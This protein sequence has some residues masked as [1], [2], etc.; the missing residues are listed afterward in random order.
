MTTTVFNG[1]KADQA[2]LA[3]LD[4]IRYCLLEEPTTLTPMNGSLIKELASGCPV[5]AARG[6]Y[7]KETTVD[8]RT[9]FHMLCNT[10]PTI[11][12]I[13]DAIKTRLRI[14]IL[15]RDL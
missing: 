11:E 5:I 12:P 4:G 14:L 10:I 6:L 2:T 8:M 1:I 13:D 9:T 15:I 3:G 7:S